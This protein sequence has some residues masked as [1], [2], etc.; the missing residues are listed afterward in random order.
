MA[1]AHNILCSESAND[2]A[3]SDLFVW[4]VDIRGVERQVAFRS[5]LGKED[6]PCHS[7]RR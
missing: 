5:G 2:H 6:K 7:H 1:N 3:N 4:S